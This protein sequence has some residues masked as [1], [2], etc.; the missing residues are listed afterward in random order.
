M[1]GSPV[2]LKEINDYLKG[3]MLT[4]GV[5]A[6]VVMAVVLALMFGVRW[7]LLP[8]LAVLFG[9]AW[10]FSLLG[11]IGIDLSLVTIAGMPILIGLGI[12]FSRSRFTTVSKRKWC[13]T[14]R[15]IRS[16]RRSPT[17]RRR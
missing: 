11:L 1:T 2:Y 3:G 6:L 16:E 7:R 17:S 12:D 15:S 4:L 8:L 13:S 14:T 9:V 5:A 10:S